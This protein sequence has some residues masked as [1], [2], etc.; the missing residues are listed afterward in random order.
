MCKA[1]LTQ[2]RNPTS[3]PT[4]FKIYECSVTPSC[5]GRQCATVAMWEPSLRPGPKRSTQPNVQPL[6]CET[7]VQQASEGSRGMN[8]SR[9]AGVERLASLKTR[10]SGTVL[11]IPGNLGLSAGLWLKLPLRLVETVCGF[12]KVRPMASID[13]L[14]LRITRYRERRGGHTFRWRWPLWTLS[15]AVQRYRPRGASGLSLN[16]DHYRQRALAWC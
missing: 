7:L 15:I 10:R 9:T 8:S 5:G 2:G 16:T 4:C 1:A 6:L 3:C 12:L 14:L 13:W 11:T